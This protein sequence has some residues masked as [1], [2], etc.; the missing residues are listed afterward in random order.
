[1]KRYLPVL[2]LIFLVSL[3]NARVLAPTPIRD[4]IRISDAVVHGF[5]N[6]YR[7]MKRP[8]KGVIVQEHSLNLISIVGVNHH[9]IVNKR[10]YKFLTHGGE[11]PQTDQNHKYILQFKN[12]EEVVLFLKATD[13]GYSVN[14]HALGKYKV[15]SNG[16]KKYLVNEAFPENKRLSNLPFETVNTYIEEKFGTTLGATQNRFVYKETMKKQGRAIASL[17]SPLNSKNTND[18]QM[19]FYFLWPLI[20]LGII[21]FYYQKK[22]RK[23]IGPKR[24][25]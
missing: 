6:K 10:S 11:W 13:Y 18:K 9:K 14:N 7:G 8:T 25:V 17:S 4:Q 5:Y 24:D 2:S 1:M 22:G 23:D 21:G 20:A 3:E 15:V 16:R 19:K 12:G